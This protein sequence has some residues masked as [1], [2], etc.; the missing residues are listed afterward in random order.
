MPNDEL[1]LDEIKEAADL[2]RRL[3]D[4]IETLCSM[5]LMNLGELEEKN[6]ED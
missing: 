5:I 1:L 3:N 6:E 4:L 2:I